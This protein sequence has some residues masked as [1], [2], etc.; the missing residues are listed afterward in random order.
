MLLARVLNDFDII[1]DP[2]KNGLASKEM[3]YNLTKDYYERKE[4]KEYLSLNSK[5]KDIFIKEHIKDYLVLYKHKLEK[6]YLKRNA[7]YRKMISSLLDNHNPAGAIMFKTYMSTLQSHL[8]SGS[9]IYTNWISTS[10]SIGSLKKYYDMQEI[11]KM[12]LIK[13]NTN[14]YIDS[15][16]I[17]TVDVSTDEKIN[18]NH[19]LYNK[20][21][22]EN[23]KLIALLSTEYPSL[24]ED[25]DLDYLIPT[26]PKSTGFRYAKSS[27]EVC[28]YE[29]LPSSHIIGLIE[30]IQ[31][32]LIEMNAFNFDYF[33]L[34][35]E[36]QEVYLKNLKMTL[37]KCIKDI[38]DSFLLHVF[39][40]LYLNNKNISS[41]LSLKDSKEKI[42][43]NRNKI[44]RL[45]RMI[46]NAQIK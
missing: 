46:P 4:D 37:L 22:C 14:G 42:I 45:A 20:I 12:A 18:N 35:K 16:R 19:F 13:T 33:N 23:P 28:I 9:K 25:F 3:L 26:N 15:D 40:E 5:E 31:M 10:K 34:N 7:L 29:Y 38:N 21:D 43:Y 36:M 27:S 6:L 17:L 44:L 39:E 41:L 32:A 24:L 30:A 2:L 11:H 8:N 1:S